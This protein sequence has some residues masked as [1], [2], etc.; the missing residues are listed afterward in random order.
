MPTICGK[1]EEQ[2]H[3]Q[4][5]VKYPPF[6]WDSDLNQFLESSSKPRVVNSQALS[7][8]V[9]LWMVNRPMLATE[10]QAS[11]GYQV[12]GLSPLHLQQQQAET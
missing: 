4:A 3:L 7:G 8:A 2:Q 11:L 1:N 5:T 9:K 10:R 6:L 12:C